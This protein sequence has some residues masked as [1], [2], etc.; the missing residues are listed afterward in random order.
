MRTLLALLCLLLPG[1]ALG[2]GRLSGVVQDSVTHQ[3]LAFAS[4]FLANTTLGATTTERGTFEFAQVPAGTYDVVGSYVGYRLTR[5]TIKVGDAPQQLT[6]RL[7]P[8]ANQLGEV[9]VRP[10]PNR[11]SDYQKFAQL[12]LG[13][14]TFSRQCR[15]RNPDDVLVDFD[16][17]AN[18]L[19]ASAIKFV[20][21]DNSALG[22]RVKYYGLRFACN[23]AQQVVT[24]YGQPVFE[25]MTPRSER[26]RRQWLANRAQAYRGSLAHFLRSV[27]D[28]QLTAQGFVA[29]RLR[30]VD[31]PRFAR[32]DSLL[33]AL[34]QQPRAYSAAEQDSLVRWARVPPSFA[35][36]YTAP[37]HLDSLRRVVPGPGGRRVF[38]GFSDRLQVTY[39]LEG[40][41]A[42]YHPQ[43][44][45]YARGPA[46]PLPQDHQVSQLVLMQ[47]EI[48]IEPNGQLA[49]P[50]A[51][52][53]DGYWGFEKMGEFLPVNYLPPFFPT[54]DN[55]NCGQRPGRPRGPDRRHDPDARGLRPLRH[56]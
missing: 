9:V 36:L 14:S 16:A 50:L 22:Y 29:R 56:S 33:R 38:L 25:E 15:I 18:E 49:Q 5:Q 34:R 21:V 12:F 28:S 23:F 37:R 53:T 3:P 35:M 46:P 20:Q 10:N 32:A 45:P 27:R 44:S 42:N 8:T 51:V 24:F 6:L 40:P 48:E 19:T 26:Q 2:Q 7:A 41:D 55:Q 11:A 17:E 43:P 4:V 54:H 13:I 30:I 52:F 47:R 1:L 31:N 39:L